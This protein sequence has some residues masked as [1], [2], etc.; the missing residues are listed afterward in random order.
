MRVTD[1]TDGS[2]SVTHREEVPQDYGSR[3]RLQAERGKDERV[4]H[5]A[6]EVEAA[7]ERKG[8]SA[9]L[10]SR[11]DAV[12]LGAG[13]LGEV[14]RKPKAQ[15]RLWCAVL[16]DP[17]LHSRNRLAHVRPRYAPQRAQQSEHQQTASDVNHG[18]GRS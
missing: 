12:P 15:T 1:E 14:V 9:F 17:A 8:K 18:F 6:E 5:E 10:V 2:S 13:V 3:R 7:F 11:R 16:N 4:S